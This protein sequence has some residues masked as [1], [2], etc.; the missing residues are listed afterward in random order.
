MNQTAEETP[1][2]LAEDF[3]KMLTANIQTAH[4]KSVI[5]TLTP[6]SYQDN[7]FYIAYESG[8]AELD[9]RGRQLLEGELKKITDDQA[10]ELMLMGASKN[11]EDD[12][13]LLSSGE[14]VW[15]RVQNNPLFSQIC[16]EFDGK[17]I[18]VRG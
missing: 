9:E 10:M 7:R 12:K 6:V 13:P 14:D 16:R 5:Q 2:S 8:Q 18:D 3:W 4:L 1:E 15:N 11:V 17:I